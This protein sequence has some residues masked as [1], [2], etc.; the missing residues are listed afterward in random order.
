[1]MM[2]FL[3]SFLHSDQAMPR[4][5]TFGMSVLDG[6]GHALCEF[7][8]GVHNILEDGLLG[9]NRS[10]VPCAAGYDQYVRG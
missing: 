9:R 4:P 1:M 10:Q 7:A 5:S 3:N 8:L 2:I 6:T